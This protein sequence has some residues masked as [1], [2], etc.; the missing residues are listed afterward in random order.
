MSAS[1]RLKVLVTWRP[2]NLEQIKN[3]L[4]GIEVHDT[5]NREEMLDLMEDAEVAYVAGFDAALF[6]RAKRLR[7]VHVAAGGVENALFPEIVLSDVTMTCV[8]SCFGT[9]AAE[10]AMSVALLFSRQLHTDLR[11]R[12]GNSWEWQ[13]PGAL[14][15][16]GEW[17]F[18]LNG[19]TFGI[20]GLGVIGKEIA[21][22]ARCFGMKV[23]A[24][25]RQTQ[26]ELEYVDEW[27][28]PEGLS[29][30]LSLSDFVIL[31]VPNTPSTR[32]MIGARELSLMKQS[33][34]FI[35]VSGRPALYDLDA[36]TEALDRKLIA[37]AS[38]QLP[39]PPSDS[40]LWNYENLVIC[41]HRIVSREETDRVLGLFC[42][43]LQF[44][45]RGL[46]LIGVV[47]KAEGY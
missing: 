22:R 15:V 38:L 47:N 21:K 4:E 37:G 43:N 28:K 33:A 27:F 8:K 34:Y 6:K 25:T 10:H 35:D 41:L 32:G 40:N 16:G 5:V 26:H 44:Y 24:L 20:I 11:H 31:A 1:D 18:E 3:C 39:L 30:L 17:P 36:I 19:K 46:P 13:V 29:S 23:L 14:R 9:T 42:E 45:Q 2:D 12:P 7:W